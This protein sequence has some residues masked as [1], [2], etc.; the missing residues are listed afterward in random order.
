MSQTYSNVDSSGDPAGAVAWQEDMAAWP[1]IAAYKRRTYELLIEARRVLD[2]GCGPGVDLVA[3]G[4]SHSFGI[5]PSSVMCMTAATRGARVAQA[6]AHALPF[7]SA[8]LDGVRADRVFQHLADPHA[9]L[10]EVD[11]VLAPGGRLVVVDPDQES[12]VIRVPGVRQSVLDRLKTL[13]RDVGYRNGRLASQLPRM[14][15]EHGLQEIG[16]EP[17]PVAIRDPDSAFG[18]PEWPILWRDE[19]SFSSEEIDEWHAALG[20]TTSGFLYV[21]TFLVVTAV[22]P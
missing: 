2:I 7:A 19:G 4:Q 18:L 9:A 1:S 16:V 12:L 11:R 15:E 6:D 5:D 22:K 17:F 20:H 21:V 10:R 3:L 8:A 14:C 13:R